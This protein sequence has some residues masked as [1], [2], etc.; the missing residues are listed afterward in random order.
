MPGPARVLILNERDARHPRAGGAE[1]HVEEIFSRLVTRGWEVTEATSA[2]RGAPSAEVVSGLR[3]RR[4]ARLPLYYPRA[5]WS[6]A[7]ETRR[8]RFDVVV[9]CLNK[10]PFYAPAYSA[11]PVL[12]IAH[13]L[14]GETAFEQV[15]WP[16]AATVWALER[17][18][19]RL[20]RNVPFVAI[21]ESTRD[22]LI[23]RGV[24]GERVRVSHC[25]LEP[26]AIPVPPMAGRGARV[27]YLGRLEPYKRVDL[28]LRAMARL[29]GRL[30][31]AEILV[32][33][34]GA[35]RARL[36][37]VAREVGVAE[38][39]R[40]TGFVSREERDRLLASCRVSVCPSPKEGWGLTVVESNAVGTPVVATDAPGLRDSVDDGKT[41]YLVPDGDEAA[42]AERIERLLSDDALAGEMSAAALAWARRFDWERAADDMAEAL[43]GA[44]AGR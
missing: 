24:A 7:R 4:L 25:G 9:E 14:F 1:V 22:D 29:A 44:I 35:D 20:Y 36:E 27:A 32:I 17:A 40:F 34:R 11:A 31:H 8:G 19:P 12:A 15:A 13:H 21:S 33:G 41:G 38:R 2:F 10:L 37:R 16:I 26:P 5:A 39:T 6:C 43:H 23:R 18:I 28:L 30:P 42:L 3:V